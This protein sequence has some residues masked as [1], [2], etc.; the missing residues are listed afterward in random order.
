MYRS[1]DALKRELIIPRSPSRSPALENLT[2]AERDRL[3]RERLGELRK[4]KMKREG[5]TPTIKREF[6]EVV[7]LTKDP[8]KPRAT[9]KTRLEDGRQ[10]DLIDLTDS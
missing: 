2:P 6:G 10:V 3:A 9:K 4:M 7:D 5:G 8:P 1:R